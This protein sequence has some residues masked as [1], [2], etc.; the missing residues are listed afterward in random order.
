MEKNNYPGTG[1]GSFKIILN[2]EH[3]SKGDILTTDRNENILI[4][5]TKVYKYT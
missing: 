5:V 2:P 3:F 1:K 4:K